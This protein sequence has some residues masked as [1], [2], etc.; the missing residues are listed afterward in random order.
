MSSFSQVIYRETETRATAH[1]GGELSA[2]TATLFAG[3]S[4]CEFN[5]N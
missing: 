5:N 3:Q 4:K 1:S 2:P